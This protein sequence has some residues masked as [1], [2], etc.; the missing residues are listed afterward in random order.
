MKNKALLVAFISAV[1]QV[2]ISVVMLAKGF[3]KEW[4]VVLLWAVIAVVFSLNSIGMDN[5]VSEQSGQIDKLLEEKERLNNAVIDLSY[6]NKMLKRKIS[7][8]SKEN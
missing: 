8:I 1:V 4:F 6:H 2:I 5:V 7:R 3:G